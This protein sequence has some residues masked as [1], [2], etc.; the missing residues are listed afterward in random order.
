MKA[1]IR[2]ITAILCGI[3]IASLP[4]IV[5]SPVMLDEAKDSVFEDE[6]EGE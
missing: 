6:D 3:I 2:I 5:S 1:Y 4:F